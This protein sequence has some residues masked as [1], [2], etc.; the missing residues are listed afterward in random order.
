MTEFS[1]W[2]WIPAI[3]ILILL[4]IFTDGDVT[5]IIFVALLIA[6]LIAVILTWIL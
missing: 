5:F 3:F 4:R 6:Y 1:R 2:F